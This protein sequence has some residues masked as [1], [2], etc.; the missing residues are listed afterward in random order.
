[1]RLAALLA[2][3]R[4]ACRGHSSSP[5][6]L[7][8]PDFLVKPAQQA[9]PVQRCRAGPAPRAGL[10]SHTPGCLRGGPVAVLVEPGEVR[11]PDGAAPGGRGVRS[12]RG[13]TMYYKPLRD[14]L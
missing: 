9:G 8:R 7:S 2:P 6:G 12:A 1:M 5:A 4:P 3:A 10:L 13:L 14:A 11:R